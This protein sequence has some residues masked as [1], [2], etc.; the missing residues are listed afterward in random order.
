MIAISLGR[1][2][3]HAV[4]GSPEYFEKHGVP[5]VPSDLLHTGV[6][7]SGPGRILVSMAV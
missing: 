4:V 7:A 2:Q 6:F 5:L 3:R 1:L